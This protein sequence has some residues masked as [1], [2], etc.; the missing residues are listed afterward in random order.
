MKYEGIRGDTRRYE[1]SS[2]CLRR[3]KEIRGVIKKYKEL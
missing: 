3:R 2:L 1:E